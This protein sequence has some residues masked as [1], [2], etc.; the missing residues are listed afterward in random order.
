MYR[1]YDTNTDETICTVEA[2]HSMTI[3]EM[4]E[5]AGAERITEEHP[6]YDPNECGDYYLD[7]KEI[8]VEELDVETCAAS[9]DRI[10][11]LR[12]QTGLSQKAFAERFGIPTRTVQNWEYGVNEAPEYLLDLLE[13]AINDDEP[14]LVILAT[15]GHEEVVFVG[16]KMSCARYEDSLRKE[17]RRRD[18]DG[19]E[20]DCYTKSPSQMLRDQLAKNRWDE[21]TEE[22]KHDFIEVDGRKYVRKIWEANHPDEL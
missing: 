5:F 21:L 16:D 6:A 3:E 22:E 2:N 20:I 14:R 15:A 8:W 12:R 1:V 18:P 19:V 17:C 11:Q 4:L 7:G 10:K 9:W 13:H